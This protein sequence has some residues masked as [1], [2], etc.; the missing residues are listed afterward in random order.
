MPRNK[1]LTEKF[2]EI[3]FFHILNEKKSKTTKPMFTQAKGLEE[4]CLLL[5][6][7]T[8][9]KVG[10]KAVAVGMPASSG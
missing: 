4:V 6:V 9:R 7:L 5:M 8:P 1:L 2:Q 10:K 3:N